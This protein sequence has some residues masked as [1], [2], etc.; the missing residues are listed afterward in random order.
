M[1]T[2]KKKLIEEVYKA[3]QNEPM[4]RDNDYILWG[5]ILQYHYQVDLVTTS[6]RSLITSV[7]KKEIPAFDS[8]ARL[9]RKVQQQYPALRGK[10]HEDRKEKEEETKLTINNHLTRKHHQGEQLNISD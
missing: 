9:R 2:F 7:V 3:L 5:Y 8:V 4:N 1:A 10:G 6:A